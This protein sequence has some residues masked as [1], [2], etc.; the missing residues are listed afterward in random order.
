MESKRSENTRLTFRSSRRDVRKNTGLFN[1]ASRFWTSKRSLLAIGK[2]CVTETNEWRQTKLSRKRSWDL[3]SS[4]KSKI[5]STGRRRASTF[6]I[7]TVTIAAETLA[8]YWSTNIRERQGFPTR[9][10]RNFE[11][12][13]ATSPRPV[14][15][16][17]KTFNYNNNNNNNILRK[18]QQHY[19][20]LAVS[21]N[22]DITDSSSPT[23]CIRQSADRCY[24]PR[25]SDEKIRSKIK[26]VNLK[27][28]STN[29]TWTYSNFTIPL[30]YFCFG[31]L[32]IWIPSEYY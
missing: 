24:W 10:T 21:R 32:S 15:P 18:Q 7:N 27:L 9:A 12:R 28:Y 3:R 1:A 26:K 23:S 20:A 30:E 11:K 16:R 5:E 31:W 22:N 29:P 2:W 6:R 19:Y 13:P 25:R 4:E 17:T 14:P 8:F